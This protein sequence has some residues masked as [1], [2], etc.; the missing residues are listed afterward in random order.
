MEDLRECLES[1]SKHGDLP[2]VCRVAAYA[3]LL[4]LEKYFNIISDCEVH[5]IA[6]GMCILMKY[7]SQAFEKFKEFRHKVEKQLDKSI[8]SFRSD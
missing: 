4:V 7:K 8:K 3:G 2:N 1:A 5:E 6:M